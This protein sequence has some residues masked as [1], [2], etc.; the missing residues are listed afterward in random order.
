MLDSDGEPEMLLELQADQIDYVRRFGFVHV[1]GFLSAIQ[2]QQLRQAAI[3]HF[4]AG[5]GAVLRGK[6]R[7]DGRPFEVE[8]NWAKNVPEVSWLLSYPPLAAIARQL[9]G[10][11][12]VFSLNGL[13]RGPCNVIW[14]RDLRRR[15][16]NRDNDKRCRIYQFGIYLQDHTQQSGGLGLW[17][18]THRRNALMGG[19]VHF[20]P[21]AA[22]DLVIFDTRITHAGNTQRVRPAA[23]ALRTRPTPASSVAARVSLRD[24]ISASVAG[25]CLRPNRLAKLVSRGFR[26][27]LQHRYLP[28][29]EDRMVIMMAFGADNDITRM[30]VDR[31]RK[32]FKDYS[33]A[34]MRKYWA[35]DAAGSE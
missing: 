29:A 23:S 15:D 34:D 1:P 27:R 22:G 17:A 5:G 14:H 33:Y 11:P 21:I 13:L 20:P 4:A 6:Q 7:R 3:G 30:F 32:K 31:Y 35:S 10:D 25:Y 19:D 2:V 16:L 12:A 26:A 24:R 8:Q 18:G 28:P 9:V